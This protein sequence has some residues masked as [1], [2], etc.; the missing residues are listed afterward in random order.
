[1]PRHGRL[2][3]RAWAD[4]ACNRPQAPVRR[5]QIASLH[6]LLLWVITAIALFVLA[7]L[8]YV[9]VRFNAKANP[10]PS[11]AT[12]NAVLEVAWTADPDPDPGSDRHSFHSSFW[13]FEA[14][15]PP[16]DIDRSRSPATAMVL[17]L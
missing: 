7:L 2:S 10:V 15:I 13:Y 9:M 6:N 5:K 14:E 12:H 17:E 8:I 3:P 1:M 11:K 16:A 4:G